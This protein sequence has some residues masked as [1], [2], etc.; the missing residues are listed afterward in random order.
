MKIMHACW[1]LNC[2]LIPLPLLSAFITHYGVD[3]VMMLRCACVE[4]GGVSCRARSL[5]ACSPRSA[6]VGSPS[7]GT[8][9][10]KVEETKLQH[11]NPLFPLTMGACLPCGCSF[12][13]LCCKNLDTKIPHDG[14]LD[15]MT[16]ESHI[17][18][19]YQ[20]LAKNK[21][22]KPKFALFAGG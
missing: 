16:L 5:H 22:I 21:L 3:C 8:E 10:L 6:I 17:K 20:I 18:S 13:V 1:T 15:A 2:H 19:I 14:P 11:V 7:D 9:Q 12:L 4:K